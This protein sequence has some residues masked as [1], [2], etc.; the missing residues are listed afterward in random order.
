MEKAAD[1]PLVPLNPGKLGKQSLPPQ[2]LK[3]WESLML[4]AI[5]PECPG[6]GTGGISA[7]VKQTF[8]KCYVVFKLCH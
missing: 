1:S 2:K 5:F 8:R 3:F 4:N 6:N 7:A